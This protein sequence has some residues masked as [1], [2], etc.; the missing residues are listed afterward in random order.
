MALTK[1]AFLGRWK[2]AAAGAAMGAA[3]LLSPLS[4]A[5]AQSQQIDLEE[6]CGRDATF[7][8][9]NIQAGQHSL[10]TRDVAIIVSGNAGNATG[11]QIG[12]F[13]KS[14]FEK[15]GIP[16]KIFLEDTDEKIGVAMSFWLKGVNYGTFGG[17]NWENGF[18]IV[19]SRYP[20][21]WASLSPEADQS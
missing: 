18:E 5:H 10:C 15:R 11:A 7:E 21:A 19:E 1:Q 8:T 4:G 12:A 3:A 6:V 20:Q 2:S 13:L 9:V 16:V 14:E 17:D